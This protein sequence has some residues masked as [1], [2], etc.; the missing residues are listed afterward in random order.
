M[1]A[2]PIVDSVSHF[3]PVRLEHHVVAHPGEDLRLGAVRTSGRLC[4]AATEGAVVFAPQ[5]EQ[6]R[7]HQMS[8]RQVAPHHVE[9]RGA[10]A[11]RGQLRDIAGDYALRRL[12]RVERRAREFGRVD[13]V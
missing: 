13:V 6:R 10:Y 5:H 7:S 9:Y 11:L 3:V 1:C 8:L 12:G 4:F 2:Q